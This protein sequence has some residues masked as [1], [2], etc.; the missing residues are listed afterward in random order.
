MFALVDCNNF[1]ASCERLFQPNLIGH[2]GA[3]THGQHERN[4]HSNLPKQKESRN[5]FLFCFYQNEIHP[6]C[7]PNG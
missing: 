7:E 4:L 5:R 3:E 2:D 1:Y 6:Y